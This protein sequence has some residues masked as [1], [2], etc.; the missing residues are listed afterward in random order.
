MIYV[1]ILIVVVGAGY[2][3]VRKHP[4]AADEA[5]ALLDKLNKK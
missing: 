3:Y 5:K 2:W 1:V 4:K